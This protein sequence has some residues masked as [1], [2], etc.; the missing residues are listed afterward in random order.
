M[1]MKEIEERI[2]KTVEGAVISREEQAGDPYLVV[3]SEKIEE[4]CRFLRDDPDLFFN[5]LTCLGGLDEKENLTLVYHLLSLRH[6]H[7]LQ[8]R[9]SVPRVN[10]E[11]RSVSSVWRGAIWFERE[12]FDLFGFHFQGHPDLRRLVLPE[13][14]EGHPL[15]K[16]YED[17]MEYQGID[18]TRDYEI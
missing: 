13:N 9:A 5:Y 14:W 11:I 2:G 16:D 12:A 10:P 4:I 15:R 17:P 7:T 1:D 6:R 18:N 8:I 3:S